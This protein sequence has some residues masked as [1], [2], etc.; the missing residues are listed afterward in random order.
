MS[1]SKK[2]ELV[3]S[4]INNLTVDFAFFI[5]E[6]VCK[7]EADYEM[8]IEHLDKAFACVPSCSK[9]PSQMIIS[10]LNQQAVMKSAEEFFNSLSEGKEEN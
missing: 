7:T 5:R 8:L 4:K 3:I 6:G 10:E 1:I 9:F 2:K